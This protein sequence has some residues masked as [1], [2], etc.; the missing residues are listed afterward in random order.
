MTSS[1]SRAIVPASSRALAIGKKVSSA[2][3]FSLVDEDVNLLNRAEVK[4]KL[5]DI[6]GRVLARSWLDKDFMEQFKSEPLDV[7]RAAGVN[8]PETIHIEF[9]KANSDR[10]KVVVYEQQENSKLK[11]RVF[12]LQLVMVAGR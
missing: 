9:Q 11:L 4:E 5:P 1:N 12:Y 2:V 7:L 3:N 6:L 10:P 8:L